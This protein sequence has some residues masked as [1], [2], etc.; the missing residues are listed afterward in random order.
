MKAIESNEDL[1]NSPSHYRL[2]GLPCESIEIIKAV[3]G[4]EGFQKFC[5]G[6][7]IKYLIRA[8]HKGGTED[9]KKAVK[10]IGWEIDV[11]SEQS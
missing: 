6:N 2:P 11:R 1:I 3:L 4:D 10:Y 7:A 8:D 9:L 5:R